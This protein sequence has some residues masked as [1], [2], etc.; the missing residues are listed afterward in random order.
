METTNLLCNS[1]RI[2]YANNQNGLPYNS[3]I[4]NYFKYSSAYFIKRIRNFFTHNR[5]CILDRF[6]HYDGINRNVK[7]CCNIFNLIT[8][9]SYSSYGTTDT[10]SNI[11]SLFTFQFQ[12]CI[13]H[14]YDI[15]F[16]T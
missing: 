11:A 2:S 13:Y 10:L 15:N 16:Q 6:L 12:C 9:N 8:L 5:Y 14:Y 7:P 4:L 1:Q 3:L